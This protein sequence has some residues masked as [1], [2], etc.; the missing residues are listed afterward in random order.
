MAKVELS[1][2]QRG[3]DHQAWMA[4]RQYLSVEAISARP[5]LVAEAQHRML[6][7]ELCYQLAHR[8]GLVW[9]RAPEPDLAAQTTI[10]DSYGQRV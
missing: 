8:L 5:G 2:D 7:G 4:Q 6:G 9:D 1:R 10:R 3:R